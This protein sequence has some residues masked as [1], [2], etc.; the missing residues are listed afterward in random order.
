MNLLHLQIVYVS[1]AL[2]GDTC[3]INNIDMKHILATATSRSVEEFAHRYNQGEMPEIKFT[4]DQLNK[5]EADLYQHHSSEKAQHAMKILRELK[6]DISLTVST[7]VSDKTH[8][9]LLLHFLV[10]QRVNYFPQQKRQ[11]RDVQLVHLKIHQIDNIKENLFME[12]FRVSFSMK[13]IN[14][15]K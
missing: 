10:F 11:T 9:T 6:N 3:T 12:I 2:Q 4:D 8:N 1:L 13:N 14:K 7:A 15:Y 5:I